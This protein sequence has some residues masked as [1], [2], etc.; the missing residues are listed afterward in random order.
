M[1]YEEFL[2]KRLFQPLGMKDTTFWPNGE[3]LQRLAKS[4]KPSADK[5]GLEETPIGQLKYPLD[6]PGRQPMPA[7]GLFSTA[8]DLSLFYRMIANGGIF[9]GRRYLSEEAVEA[10]D[11]EADRRAAKRPMVSA[12]APAATDRSRRRLQHQQ[13][14]RHRASADH[15]LPG[16]ARLAGRRGPEDLLPAFHKAAVE[17]FASPASKDL[18]QNRI[19]SPC[20]TGV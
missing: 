18:S 20:G 13:Q 17:A 9:A 14:L 6:D 1:P 10:D 3:Q 7:G 2:D 11:L 19:E 12:S 8:T 15:D 5:K 4:Y 16:A